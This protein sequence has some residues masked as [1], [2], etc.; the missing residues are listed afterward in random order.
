MPEITVLKKR[1]EFLLAAKSGFK[2]VK[3][4]IVIQSRIRANEEPSA[5]EIRVGFTATKKLGN[6]VIRN[7]AKRRMRAASDKITQ[8][9]G[10]KGCDYVMIGRELVYKGDFTSL[11]RDMRHAMR[12][13]KEQMSDQMSRLPTGS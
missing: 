1:S 3:P 13:L 12:I 6:A 10:L 9:F 4:S 8:E 11:L 5:S 2:F 7:R